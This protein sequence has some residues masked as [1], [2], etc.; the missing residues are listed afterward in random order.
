MCHQPSHLV[1]KSHSR[2]HGGRK[3]APFP[4]Q[5]KRA[6]G[7]SHSPRLPG[8][9][10]AKRKHNIPRWRYLGRSWL[11][12]GM[13]TLASG[14]LPCTLFHFFHPFDNWR[15][16][17][18]CQSLRCSWRTSLGAGFYRRQARSL[19]RKSLTHE[20][21]RK[22]LPTQHTVCPCQGTVQMSVKVEQ[23]HGPPVCWGSG[24]NSPSP[25]SQYSS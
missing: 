20:P 23:S 18:I 2:P 6:W 19:C 24:C 22:T 4:C 10:C 15:R 13:S 8:S 1:S 11:G 16:G 9:T 21:Q 25:K 3:V 17:P 7:W 5:D 12:L 14:L